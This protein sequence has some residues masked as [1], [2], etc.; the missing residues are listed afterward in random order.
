[1]VKHEDETGHVNVLEHGEHVYEHIETL[2]WFDLDS[3]RGGNLSHLKRVEAV[4]SVEFGLS[5]I[6]VG[7][8][9]Q[10]NL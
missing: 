9:T 7:G 5:K 2:T 4:T 10:R 8:Q 1:M 3:R 6:N